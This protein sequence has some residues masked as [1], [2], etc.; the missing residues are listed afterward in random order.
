MKRVFLTSCFVIMT[1]ATWAQWGQTCIVE[2]PT[3]TPLNVRSGPNGPMLGALHNGALV[4][5]LDTTSDERGSRWAY[6]A[7]VEAGK[8][9][10]V[11]GAYLRCGR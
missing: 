1:T 8:R 3:G 9:G 11:Y 4:R 10:W 5:I 6:I 2:D 7:P